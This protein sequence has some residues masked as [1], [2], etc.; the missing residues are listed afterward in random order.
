VWPP[1]FERM[2]NQFELPEIDAPPPEEY[3]ATS[4]SN[5]L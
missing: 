4:S 5:D 3:A 1:T 2:R